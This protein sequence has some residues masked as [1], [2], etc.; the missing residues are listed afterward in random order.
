MS[1]DFLWQIALILVSTKVCGLIT[2]RFQMPQVVGALLAGLL[3]GPA[4]FGLLPSDSE[5]IKQ[6]AELGVIVIMFSAGME[7]DI[8][9]LKNAGKSGFLVAM[10]G[11]LVPLLGGAGLAAW[12]AP[13]ENMLQNFFIGTVL[14]ATSVSITVEALR[15]MGRLQ[16]RVGNTILAAA[17]IDDILGIIALTIMTSLGGGGESIAVVLLKIVLFL[18]V[19]CFVY[20][21]GLKVL[22]WYIERAGRRD[23]RRFPIAAFVVCL[24]MAWIAEHFFGV[25]DITGAFAAGLMIGAT[26]KAGYI[27]SKFEPVQY[28]FLAP[29][30]FASIGMT[31]VLPAMSTQIVIF[32]VLLVVV[33]VLSKWLGCGVGAKM[34]GFTTRECNQIGLGM[35]CRG[36]VALI[37]ANKGAEVGLMPDALF[38]PVI[39]MVIISTI[40]TP[41]LLKLAYR[42]ED[43]LQLEES[44][45]ENRSEALEQLDIVTDQL[46]TR[47]Q[48]I[49]E[50]NQKH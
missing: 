24:M 9:D 10:L 12:L 48:E 19:C 44:P 34:C 31:V 4:V 45:L 7:T 39:I 30:F 8:R 16:S 27:A 38:A 18:V 15:E 13:T 11:V 23:L 17:I 37:V 50:K 14:T 33:A 2:R 1:Y 21:V 35:V 28:L 29:V 20:V 46:L 26:K 47:E 41:I 42:G 32:S 25:A 6:L 40:L 36:E 5:M 49:K 3:L 43:A 22:D